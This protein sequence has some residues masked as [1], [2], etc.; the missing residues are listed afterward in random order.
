MYDYLRQIEEMAREMSQSVSAYEYVASQLKGSISAIA[1]VRDTISKRHELDRELFA[2][3]SLALS[4]ARLI[5][6]TTSNFRDMALANLGL[7]GLASRM[8]IPNSSL[9]S[10]F[11]EC[12]ALQ[13]S[14]RSVVPQPPITSLLSSIDTTRF[15]STSLS[16]QSR[17]LG[18]EGHSFGGLIGAS[19]VLTNN[20]T[21]NFSKLTR[22]Y[23]D[24]VECLP[25]IPE[26]IVPFIAKSAPVEYSLEMDVLERISLEGDEDIDDEG[27]PSID[28]ELASHDDRLLILVKGAREALLSN[29]PDRVR[30]VTISAR[31]LFTHVLHE[32]APDDEIRKWS[33]DKNHYHNNRPTRRARLL[34]ICRK[35]S[36]DPLAKYV[37]DDVRAV[38]SFNNLLDAEVHVVQPRLTEHQLKAIVY[39]MEHLVLYL[40]RISR[41]I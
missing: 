7:V 24:V 2:T 34:Y 13:A 38:L 9:A 12:S 30:H 18:L 25:D 14:L 22:S 35:F 5:E 32:L 17:M 40:L 31:T 39:R 23:R 20:L 10:V 16:F 6:S 19:K 29:N 15:L 8:A 28:E 27:L 37:E 11:A 33:T 21:A 4:Q 3:A 36:C 1:S 41:E 26:P